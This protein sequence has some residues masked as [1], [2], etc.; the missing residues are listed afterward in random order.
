MARMKPD[1]F[2]YYA[3]DSKGEERVYNSLKE[4]LDDSWLVCHSWRW[5][6]SS[7]NQQGRKSQ[8]E[9]DFVLFHPSYGIIVIEV[10]GGTI[11]YREDGKYYSNG[12]QIQDPAKQASDTKYEIIGRLKNKKL[13]TECR[14]NYCVWFPDIRWSIPFPPSLNSKILFDKNA[15]INPE[16]YLTSIG[17]SSRPISDSQKIEAIEKLLFFSFKLVKNLLFRIEDNLDE[18][19]RMTSQQEVISQSLGKNP[20]LGVKGRAGTGKTLIATLK[21]IEFSKLGKKVLYLCSGRGLSEFLQERLSPSGVRVFTFHKYALKYL[22][23]HHSARL[24][25]DINGSTADF[26]YILGAYAEVADEN[27]D[28]YDVCIIDEAQDLRSDVFDELRKAFIGKGYFYYFYDPLQIAFSRASSVDDPF[29]KNRDFIFELWKNMRNTVEVSK[30]SL[31]IMGLNY[32]HDRD[33][34][35][36]SG[37]PPTVVLIE[38][39]IEDHVKKKIIELTI[40][41]RIPKSFI[42]I[43]SMKG[44]G[45][46]VCGVEVEGIEVTTFRKF[47]GLD[48]SIVLLVDVTLQHFIDEVYER[49]LYMAMT[50]SKYSVVLFVEN[51]Q[52]LMKNEFCRKHNISAP[53]AN[54]ILNLLMENRYE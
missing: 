10:K 27:R 43:L 26:E 20:I 34:S 39:H 6:R 46:S 16:P 54:V 30:A 23:R 7:Q 3:T 50:R 44:E 37:E 32:Q 14:V 45:R 31:N 2:D 36:L 41:D 18:H 5:I 8:G 53:D 4:H 22:Q 15:L 29:E 1:S 19:L 17:S 51:G 42:S 52:D 40:I 28:N 13:D 48:I 35:S 38:N 9:G 49:E 11:E 24:P 21:A 33:F 25:I 12:I 47:K